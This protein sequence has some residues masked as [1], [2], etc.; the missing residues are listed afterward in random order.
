M[1]FLQKWVLLVILGSG[2]TLS[3]LGLINSLKG[4]PLN[5][6]KFLPMEYNYGTNMIILKCVKIPKTRTKVETS[7]IVVP[8]TILKQWEKT[9]QT[10][11]NLSYIK[12]FNTKSL[13]TFIDDVM[14]AHKEEVNPEFVPV[15]TMFFGWTGSFIKN[16]DVLL[17]SST[18]YNKV[19]G[20]INKNALFNFKIKLLMK[21][22]L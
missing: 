12:I 18:Q 6:K 5:I 8:H 15:P 10:Q 20:F 4:T 13:N 16:Y 7:V 9:I 17:I 14:N 19:S 3:I 11:T 1:N 2:K 21:Q 22:T